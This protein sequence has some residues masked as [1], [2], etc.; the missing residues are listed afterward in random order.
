[1][2]KYGEMG[3]DG[4]EEGGARPGIFQLYLASSG[5]CKVLVQQALSETTIDGSVVG[6]LERV[7]DQTWEYIFLFY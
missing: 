2:R 6:R 5:V 7:Q 3:R 4:G 1:M